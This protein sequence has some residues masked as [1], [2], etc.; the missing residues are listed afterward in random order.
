[1]PNQNTPN[2]RTADVPKDK[3]ERPALKGDAAADGKK[4][5]DIIDEQ[6]WESFPGSDPPSSWAGKDLT[7]E[8]RE[9]KAKEQQDK[10]G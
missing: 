7:P 8:E 5:W 10:K 1:M 6:A 2:P 9:A 4:K 3:T